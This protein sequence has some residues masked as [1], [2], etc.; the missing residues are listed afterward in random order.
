MVTFQAFQ[1][2]EPAIGLEEQ[3]IRTEGKDVD[4]GVDYDRLQRCSRGYVP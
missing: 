1:R 4:E 2:Q 3:S